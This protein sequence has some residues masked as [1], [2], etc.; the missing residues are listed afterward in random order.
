MERIN[1]TNP[2]QSGPMFG[3]PENSSSNFR[4]IFHFLSKDKFYGKLP[5]SLFPEVDFAMQRGDML[6]ARGPQGLLG[7]CCWKHLSERQARQA[8]A[9]RR[10]PR[11]SQALEPGDAV[12]LTLITASVS[13]VTASL[14]RRVFA[15]HRG[16]IV[17]YERHLVRG[18]RQ[19]RF[20]WI[21]KQGTRLGM[22][23][24]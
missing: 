13:G 12:L 22:S 8:I 21:D 14:A 10:L 2:D 7:L 19:D 18:D 24:S 17:L 4:A 1:G 11:Q 15:H 16:R 5:L 6:C 20:G 23:L 3:R 9:E